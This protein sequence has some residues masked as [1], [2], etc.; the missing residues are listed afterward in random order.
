MAGADQQFARTR[1]RCSAAGT[2]RLDLFDEAS[3][4]VE[5]ARRLWDS[6]EDDAESQSRP[7]DS[8]TA[9]SCTT[10]TSRESTSPSRGR[11]SP[12]AHPRA[13]PSSPR[14]R[15]KCRSTNS[16][17]AVPISSS[18]PRTTTSSVRSII[19]RGRRHV[20]GADL[21]VYADVYVAFAGGADARSDALVFDG[22]PAELVELL[23]PLAAPR[24]R[25]LPAAARGQRHRPAGHRRR[26]GAAPAGWRTCS[27]PR[28]ATANSCG[29]GSVF[30]SPTIA[31]RR[32]SRHDRA[33]VDPRPLADQRGQRRRDRAA[34][35]RRPR[36]ARRT[37]GVSRL[38]DGRAPLRR[39]GELV[40]RGVDRPDRRG[41]RAHPRRRGRGAAGPHHRR[42]RRR[43]LRHARR[44]PPRP[45]RPRRRPVRPAPP[46][47]AKE[48]RPSGAEAQATCDGVARGRRRRRAAAVRHQRVDAQPA[49][50]GPG[51]RCCS[52]PR[53][54]RRT[55]TTRSTTS[56]RCSTA[57][58][59]STASTC[60]PCRGASRVDAV[61]IR[62]QQGAERAGG[63]RRNGL[64]FVASYHIT[65]ATALDAVDVYRNGVHAVGDAVGALRR[66]VG[67]RRGG[68][69]HRHRHAPRLHLRALGVLDPRGR[70][71]RALSR[72]GHRRAAHRRAAR[73][74]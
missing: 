33:P 38:L 56:S 35:H 63:R 5:V 29:H 51:C 45:H 12:R 36:A 66:G 62:Q 25:R 71:R 57:R 53:P 13:S 59:A 54:S 26:G 9:T 32:W 43:E 7:V 8:S 47:G 73:A 10:S 61:G 41:H 19:G 64:P 44:V 37:V 68:R 21:K 20:G 42:R 30:P 6:W 4:A 2:S 70:R 39:R 46:R 52:S 31:T 16:P 18:S 40:A 23:L 72:P 17:R 15:I 1:P 11:R 60:T 27:A 58:Y 50:C 48:R 28:T 14:W 49:G 24:R 69:R 65:P 3:D 67:R 22:S 55:S 34:Q 74:W